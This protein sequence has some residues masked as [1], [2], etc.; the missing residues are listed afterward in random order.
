[1]T[2]SV[3]ALPTGEQ[4]PVTLQF[5]DAKGNPAVAPLGVVPTWAVDHPELLTVTPA[6]DGL[7]AV[8]VTVGPT[9]VAVVTVTDGN[10]TGTLAVT[11]EA[12]VI[13]GITV[14]PGVPTPTT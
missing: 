13:T 6:A 7:T 8:A 14:V 5:V 1:M 4:F 11:V 2:D 9:G 10:I 12:G 3:F